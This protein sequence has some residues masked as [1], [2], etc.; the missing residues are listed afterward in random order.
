M[1][2]NSKSATRNLNLAIDWRAG[3]LLLVMLCFTTG[4]LQLSFGDNWLD[5]IEIT[6]TAEKD[7]QKDQQEKQQELE[8]DD[9]ISYSHTDLSDFGDQQS[10]VGNSISEW[11]F[12]Y[13]DISTPPPEVG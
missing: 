10:R 8:I 3:F 12:A 4:V 1:I 9:Y 2:K 11:R 6:E 13:F 5:Q 7:C